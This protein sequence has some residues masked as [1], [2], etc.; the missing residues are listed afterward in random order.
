MAVYAKELARA[1][2]IY[3]S[4]ALVAVGTPVV[5]SFIKLPRRDV[6]ITKVHTTG[7]YAIT[8]AWSMDGTNVAFTTTPTM[9]DNVP[10]T[11]NA[12]APWL[13]VTITATGA[14]FTVHQTTVMG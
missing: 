5:S 9:V 14:G 12:L 8:L 6:T 2:T 4:A 3:S 1:N 13:R 11:L 10:Q 7:T